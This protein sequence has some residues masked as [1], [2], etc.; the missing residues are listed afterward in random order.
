MFI[1]N[2]QP[3]KLLKIASCVGMVVNTKCVDD[4]FIVVCRTL[5]KCCY[6]KIVS[7]QK[8]W[9]LL[10]L[11]SM[12]CPCWYTRWQRIKAL[13]WRTQ[14]TRIFFYIFSF[15]YCLFAR[16]VYWANWRLMRSSAQL[17]VCV[18]DGQPRATCLPTLFIMYYTCSYVELVASCWGVQG[19]T[20]Y[21]SQA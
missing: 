9:T 10:K 8:R 4:V 20:I 11:Q 5:K 15:P 6:N 12:R 7:W 1:A 3:Q 13:I 19:A 18:I 16:V 17:W 2:S 14:E 21:S